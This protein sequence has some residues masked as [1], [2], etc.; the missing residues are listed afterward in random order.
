ML[1]AE[2]LLKLP[3]T[4]QS[5]KHSRRDRKLLTIASSHQGTFTRTLLC[6]GSHVKSR[7]GCNQPCQLLSKSVQ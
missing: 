4:T 7:V 1:N 6:A 5:V 3:L 2:C